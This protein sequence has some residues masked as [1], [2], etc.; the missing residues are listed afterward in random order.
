MPNSIQTVIR[1]AAIIFAE[2][3]SLQTVKTVRRRFIDAV[4]VNSDN[5][6]LTVESIITLLQRNHELVVQENEIIPILS[7]AR[8]FDVVLGQTKDEN[9]YYLPS[10]R[11]QKLKEKVD[12]TLDDAI[13]DYSS[14]ESKAQPEELRDL[15]Y[16]F[17]YALLNT[18]IS[19]FTQLLERKGKISSSIIDS[20]SFN[21]IEIETINS[22]INWDNARK[23]KAL[24]EVVNYCIDYATAINSINPQDIV[25]ALRNKSLYLDNALIYRAL[26]INGGFRKARVDNLLARCVKSGQ[27]LLI[28]SVTRKEFFET[29]DF[30]I[31]QLKESSPYGRIDPSLFRE[32]TGGYTLYQY[33]HDWRRERR[34]YGFESF[35]V[36]IKNEYEALLNR[37]HIEEDF[38]QR[39]NEEDEER[40]NRY[41]T[42]I[43]QYKSQ[44]NETLF[45]NDAKNMVWLELA[46]DQCDYNV[47]DTK[48]YFVTSDRRLQEWDLQ[49]SKNQPI[50]ML[51]SQW[52]ALLLKYF[53]QSND[54]YKSFVSFLTIPSEKSIVSPEELQDILAGI[55]EITEDF[56]K[57]GDIVS[58]LLESDNSRL[59]RNRIEAK[60]FAQIHVETQF[61]EQLRLLKLENQKK[62]EDIEA[63]SS[64]SL[65]KQKEE[66][67]KIINDFRKDRLR[68]KLE[69]LKNERKG[70]IQQL[71][72]KEIIKKQID[73]DVS[74]SKDYLTAIIISVYI[75]LIILAI[76]FICKYGWDVMEPITWVIG[77]VIF[78]APFIYSLST[79]KTLDCRRI[80]SEY[81]DRVCQKKCKEFGF[82]LLDIDD[83]KETI[84]KLDS[85]ISELEKDEAIRD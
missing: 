22:F 58:A 17:L 59:L 55:S 73:S 37:Y 1:T 23:D 62:M 54:D 53:S 39:F 32:Y 45:V 15:L 64:E 2:D 25:S 50:T 28:S 10:K 83:L 36:H 68:D 52:L 80:V 63:A 56:Q 49:H 70:F 14:H 7:D 19:A 3:Q 82:N 79:N 77:A 41:A 84:N 42:E 66:F 43:R 11:F 4:L 12:Y 51:P 29:I 44:K 40:I 74:L 75:I 67:D 8:Y 48:Y 69:G 6:P 81:G 35:R 60:K 72:D 61:Q 9:T 57:Q 46:R 76:C 31:S 27:K 13:R 20:S 18:N 65:K 85:Q 30:H 24:F 21:E 16:R 38:K 5:N 26:G 33:Y 47:N 34:V 78:V 71:N